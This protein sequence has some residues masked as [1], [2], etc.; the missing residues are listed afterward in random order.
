MALA[1]NRDARAAPMAVRPGSESTR[2]EDARS[3]CTPS[4]DWAIARGYGMSSGRAPAREAARLRPLAASAICCG[5]RR[6]ETRLSKDQKQQRADL[7]TRLNDAAEAV[8][9]ALV[10]VNGKLNSA[11]ENYNL[12][13]S[14]VEA[15]RDEIVSEM[16]N[17]AS[18]RSDRWQKSE[19]SHRHEAWKQEW[20]GLDV[21]ALDA[22]DGIDEPEM[23]HANELESIRSQPE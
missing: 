22:I 10:A 7:V 21:T 1:A 16:E 15:F 4:R 17:Y 19:K 3:C 18:D 20:E 8:R 13:V 9:A 11:I 5:V 6:R 23:A 2:C 12:V 14:V